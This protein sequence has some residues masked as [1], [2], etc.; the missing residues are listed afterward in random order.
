MIS[1]SKWK[2]N[3]VTV[4]KNTMI[5]QKKLNKLMIYLQRKSNLLKKLQPL[6]MES[7]LLKTKRKYIL[8]QMNMKMS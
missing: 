8:K 1:S 6:N 7:E 5:D 4:S 3:K 2:M